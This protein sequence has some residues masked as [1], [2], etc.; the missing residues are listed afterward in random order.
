MRRLDVLLVSCGEAFIV[1]VAVFLARLYDHRECSVLA[2]VRV[3]RVASVVAAGGEAVS[4]WGNSS[5]RGS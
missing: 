3:S 1:S 4:G 5:R 2:S